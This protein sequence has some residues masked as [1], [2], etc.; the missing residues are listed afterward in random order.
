MAVARSHPPPSKLSKVAGEPRAHVE[1]P[2][3]ARSRPKPPS[4]RGPPR[5]RRPPPQ[6]R[7]SPRPPPRRPTPNA[8]ACRRRSPGPTRA[9]TSWPGGEEGAP[10]PPTPSGF[11]V[12]ASPWRRGEKELVGGGELAGGA[13]GFPLV[14]RGSDAGGRGGGISCCSNSGVFDKIEYLILR[15]ILFQI[16]LKLV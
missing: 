16:F 6:R 5:Y 11:A 1:T 4:S 2:V 9:M 14:A 13:L 7:E 12:G 8:A 3:A 15:F 10:P